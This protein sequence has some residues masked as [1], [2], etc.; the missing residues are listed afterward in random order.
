MVPGNV[1]NDGRKSVGFST[2]WRLM[3]AID[4][5]RCPHR[6][7]GIES[8][9]NNEEHGEANRQN[10]IEFAARPNEKQTQPKAQIIGLARKCN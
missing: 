6:R 4:E 2:I 10:N 3:Y 5:L 7:T 8:L 9:F 1:E